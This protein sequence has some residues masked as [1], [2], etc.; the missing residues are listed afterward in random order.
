MSTMNK[1]YRKTSDSVH[2]P[3]EGFDMNRLFIAGKQR[4]QEIPLT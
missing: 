3:S 2:R 1:A 4:R